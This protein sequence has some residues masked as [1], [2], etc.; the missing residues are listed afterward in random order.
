MQEIEHQLTQSGRP[1]SLFYSLFES[2]TTDLKKK[3]CLK[4]KQKIYN[5]I[6]SQP[7][8]REITESDRVA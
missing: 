2:L 5:N 4:R 1:R 7:V 6:R 3:N 8:D